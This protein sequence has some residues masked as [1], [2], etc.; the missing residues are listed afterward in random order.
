M[1]NP[2]RER[3]VET[4]RAAGTCSEDI[5]PPPIHRE[6]KTLH[7]RHQHDR[8]EMPTCHSRQQADCK[9]RDAM[10]PCE[11]KHRLAT[12]AIAEVTQTIRQGLMSADWRMSQTTARTHQRIVRRKEQL[13]E[14]DRRTVARYR[15]L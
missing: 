6:G 2:L 9:S 12:Y 1:A 7:A 8:R 4:R 15:N 13:V 5:R 14:H 10:S 11:D 3:T